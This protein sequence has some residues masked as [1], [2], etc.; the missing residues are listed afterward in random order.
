[1]VHGGT[2]KGVNSKLFCTQQAVGSSENTK[3]QYTN[4][5]YTNTQIHNTQIQNT[6]KAALSPKKEANAYR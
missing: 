1:M 6:Q 2:L 3:T 5:Q 4:T